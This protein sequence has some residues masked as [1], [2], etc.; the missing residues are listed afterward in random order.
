[1]M[2]PIGIRA[3][4]LAALVAACGPAAAAEWR[5]DPLA[6]S[7]Q[8]HATQ[9]GQPFVGDFKQFSGHITFNPG[10]SPT[11]D[12]RIEIDLTS[13]STGKA[14][15]DAQ[16]QG[17]A[18]FATA[19]GPHAV[20]SAARFRRI[21]ALRYEAIGTLAIKGAQAPVVLPF[22][23]RLGADGVAEMQGSTT[24][25]RLAFGLGAGPLA[26][27]AMVGRQVTVDIHLRA[28]PGRTP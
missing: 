7:I 24:L 1:M 28:S 10:A 11:G 13:L 21:D 16:A 19:N 23:L 18:W 12:V 15:R 2:S 27:P 14:D 6:S 3:L 17:S 25:D 5:I 20:F 9:F 26:D 8:F 4:V 22:T